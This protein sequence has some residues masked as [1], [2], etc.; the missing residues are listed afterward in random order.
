VRALSQAIVSAKGRRDMCFFA[1]HLIVPYYSSTAREPHTL[2]IPRRGAAMLKAKDIMTTNVISVPP[3]MTIEAFARLLI[4]NR[5]SGAPVL[6][7]SGALKGIVTENDLISQNKR[8]HIPTIIRLFDAY[9]MLGKPDSIEKELKKMTGSTVEEIC[10]KA[11]ITITP[12]TSIE[13][14]AT[15]MAERKVHLLPV[16]AGEKLA[17][18]VG[19][20]DLIKAVLK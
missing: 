19:K 20:I 6:D 13:E 10:T 2:I 14:I 12:D 1:I 4:E 7:E 9:I 8:L 11:V 17:G 16:V 3:T 18:I 5:I 15:I